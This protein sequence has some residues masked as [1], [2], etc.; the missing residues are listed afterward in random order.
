MIGLYKAATAYVLP[1]HGEGW[2]LPYM[3]AM[4]MGLP[5]IATDWGGNLE[6]MSRNTSLL[7]RVAGFEPSDPY[8]DW[9][10]NFHWAT[11]DVNHLAELMAWCFYNPE[12]AK[13]LGRRARVDVVKRFSNEAVAEVI[14]KRLKEIKAKVDAE[15]SIAARG[16]AGQAVQNVSKKPLGT[17]FQWTLQSDVKLCG[18]MPRAG[19]LGADH[20]A[21]QAQHDSGNTAFPLPQN[22]PKAQ[23][24]LMDEVTNDQLQTRAQAESQIQA[25]RTQAGK[26]NQGT[27]SDFVVHQEKKKK[28]QQH[29]H[30]VGG[31]QG[32]GSNINVNADAGSIQSVQ[33]DH[34]QTTTLTDETQKTDTQSND[35]QSINQSLQFILPT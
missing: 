11:P 28:A 31:L 4:A 33:A 18:N 14:M 20:R 10:R 24:A 34:Q 26:E 35:D 29:Q 30:L 9:L 13:E 19:V 3:E 8:D 7:V 32:S 15:D 12:K 21:Q 25:Q 2:G 1:T 6:F 17:A 16:T 27:A 22:L 5:T 23:Q